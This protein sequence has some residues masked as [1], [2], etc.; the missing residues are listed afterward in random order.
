MKGFSREQ[1]Q[2]IGFYYVMSQVDTRNC[3]GEEI[4]KNIDWCSDHEKRILNQQI[5]YL[6]KIVKFQKSHPEAVSQIRN[7]LHR[8]K[9]IRGILRK[10]ERSEEHL[11][12]TE[13]FEVKNFAIDMEY[14]LHEYFRTRL[15]FEKIRPSST[16]K[17]IRLLNPDGQIT[18]TFAIYNS[19]SKRL[20]A[21]R[22]KK[23]EVE[24][25]ILLYSGD[26]NLLL[27]KR[28]E[29]TTREKTEENLVKQALT[30]KLRSYMDKFKTNIRFIGELD[31]LL[32]KADLAIRYDC[33]KPVF[34]ER[35]S[36]KA[37]D[38]INPYVES[39][40]QN[41]WQRFTPISISMKSGANVLTG[42][43]MGGKTVALAT[44]TL[45]IL[46][47]HC[48][49]FVF[50]KSLKLPIFDSIFY[51]SHD[52][53]SIALGLSS[54]GAEI[55]EVTRLIHAMRHEKVF[56]ALDEFA[57]GTNPEEGEILVRAFLRLAEQYRTFA[58]VSTHFSG[59][60]R[61]GMNHFQV[62]GLKNSDLSRFSAIKDL[63]SPGML[64]QLMD[65]RI[66]KV[67]WN[68]LPPRDAVRVAELMGIQNEFLDLVRENYQEK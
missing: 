12:E 27:Q 35:K 28:L 18:R 31:F 13:L 67:G 46:L 15:D 49:F 24:N 39:T 68:N 4:K 60:V 37:N 19:Y 10:I 38:I 52:Y 14:L 45:N 29:I 53:Q 55:K 26:R 58:L 1:L 47:A 51:L 7:I 50:G 34:T 66:G 56:C 5:R 57:K 16:R 33:S 8:F 41:N 61:K 11:D 54:F 48:G 3:F 25:Q 20:T 22:K 42:A 65:Y 59:V 32:A 62:V 6:S 30:D 9:D 44:I 63:P 17:I 40:L 43:N 23:L 64:Q 36:I 2:S 21:I